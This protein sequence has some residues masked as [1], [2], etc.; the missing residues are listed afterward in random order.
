ML[1]QS[2]RGASCSPGCGNSA[3]TPRLDAVFAPVFHLLLG[4]NAQGKTN[5]LEARLLWPHCARSAA[6]A[7][8]INPA[9]PESYFVG[10]GSDRGGP[11]ETRCIGR[12]RNEIDAR[13]PVCA[14]VDRDLG[15]LRVVVF[16][17]DDL[18]LVK[19]TAGDGACFW[20]YC[21]H[22]PTLRISRY[23]AYMPPCAPATPTQRPRWMNRRWP[24]SPPITGPVGTE[25]FSV[26]AS[27]CRDCPRRRGCESEHFP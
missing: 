25:S 27:C 7:A 19:G 14:P 5:I 10:G 15:T 23:S 21:S 6:W 17:T 4:D 12:P 3:F 1:P 20:I 9:R 13:R 11:H 16:C 22:K 24:V 26:A 8:R 18:Q 2:G